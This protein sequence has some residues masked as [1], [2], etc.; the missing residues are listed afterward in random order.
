MTTV[1]Y[2]YPRP[3]AV[4]LKVKGYVPYPKSALAAVYD[5]FRDIEPVNRAH[6]EKEPPPFA[7]KEFSRSGFAITSYLAL[8]TDMVSDRL[9]AK[10]LFIADNPIYLPQTDLPPL[11][12]LKDIAVNF[13][14]PTAFKYNTGYVPEFYAPI[15]IKSAIDSYKRIIPGLPEFSVSDILKYIEFTDYNLQKSRYQLT[16]DLAIQGFKGRLRLRFKPVA[17]PELKLLI[18]YLLESASICGVGVKKAWGMGDL[19]I[20]F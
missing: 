19:N 16:K 7:V 17:V 12:E 4:K 11:Y 14:T 10:G 8:P 13:T 18:I 6:E 1:N 5:I 2:P 3:Q 15:F 9:K 20:A